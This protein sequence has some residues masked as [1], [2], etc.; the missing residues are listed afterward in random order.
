MS[1]ATVQSRNQP[2]LTSEP[3]PPS[4][5]SSA[6]AATTWEAMLAWVGMVSCRERRAGWMLSG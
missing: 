6:A 2:S 5:G 4:A 3:P 1:R